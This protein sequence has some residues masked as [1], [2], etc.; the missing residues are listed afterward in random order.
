MSTWLVDKETLTTILE[1]LGY[2]EN[3]NNKSLS[4]DF[5]GNK[6]H[7]SVKIDTTDATSFNKSLTT[8]IVTLSIGFILKD[9][10][11]NTDYH[12]SIDSFTTV[13]V[14][15]TA[16]APFKNFA[17]EHITTRV[18]NDN[19]KLIHSIEFYYGLHSC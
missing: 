18:S 10:T 4:E 7:L 15:I 3:P 1:N 17:S 19:K 9:S 16:S 11:E 6:F 5:N 8:R 2:K 13:L 14:G 12:T